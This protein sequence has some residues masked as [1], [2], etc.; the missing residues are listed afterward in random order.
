[1]EQPFLLLNNA[2]LIFP[3]EKKLIEEKIIPDFHSGFKDHFHEELKNMFVEKA[4]L[5]GIYFE[6]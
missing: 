3:F 6:Q 5:N 1:M 4:L 2:H